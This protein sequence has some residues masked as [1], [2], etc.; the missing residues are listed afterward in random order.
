M[1]V[2]VMIRGLDVAMWNVQLFGC[3]SGLMRKGKGKLSLTANTDRLK[4]QTLSTAHLLVEFLR[5][6]HGWLYNS[7]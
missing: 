2:V 6:S 4:D 3:I 5:P 7:N 1:L